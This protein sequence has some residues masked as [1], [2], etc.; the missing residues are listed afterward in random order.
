M[1]SLKFPVT[2]I[3][4]EQAA[5]GCALLDVE[6]AKQLVAELT[7]N[8]FTYEP[9]KV[10]FRAI[11]SLSQR[12]LDPDP[13]TVHN[14]LQTWG[15]A[16]ECGGVQYLL[17]LQEIPPALSNFTDYLTLVKEAALRHRVWEIAQQ[18]AEAATKGNGWQNLVGQF[19]RSRRKQ[20]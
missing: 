13:I 10:I 19:K 9:H 12:G 5:L 11:R 8:D 1:G 14:T 6:C 16:D 3:E 15:F 17:K 4:A 18:L 7:E 2:N 20:R